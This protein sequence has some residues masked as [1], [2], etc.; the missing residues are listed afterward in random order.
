M[1]EGET[2]KPRRGQGV[3]AKRLSLFA[4]PLAVCILPESEALKTSLSAVVHAS[5]SEATAQAEN[6][7][8]FADQPWQG[9]FTPCDAARGGLAP[10]VEAAVILVDAIAGNPAKTW[11]IS[12][13][14]EV[15]QP[16]QGSEVYSLPNALWC[17]HYLID[18][19][20]VGV[21]A[22]GGALELQ[23]PRGAAPVMYAP[24]LTF[25]AEGAETLGVSQ[26][27]G[28]KEGA[29]AVFPAWMLQSNRL[30]Q[31]NRP[32]LSLTLKLTMQD[33]G[34]R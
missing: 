9:A 27:I 11:D 20:G 33:K 31:G 5:Y 2:Q 3:Q 29:L 24:G 34:E 19:G 15:L 18:A 17:A 16:G 6:G 25:A 26:T 30:H 12:W 22:S 1:S 4:T 21:G 32:R 10:L 28:L 14:G 13:R 8:G 23:D 7:D